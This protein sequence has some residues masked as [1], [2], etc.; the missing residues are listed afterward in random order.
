MRRLLAALFVTAAMLA[1][2]VLAVWLSIEPPRLDRARSLSPEI[3]DANGELLRA[4][5]TPASYWRLD[6]RVE[7]VSPLYLDM[8]IAYEDARFASHLGVD[9]LAL[10][11]AG[12]QWLRFGRAVSGASTLTMQT[13]RLLE[14]GNHGLGY[15]LWQLGK[16]LA[17]E[18][19]ESK[20]EILALYLKLAPFGGNL[21]GVRAASLAYFGKEPLRLSAAEA[22]LLVA[23]PQG[24][25][26][27]PDRFPEAARVARDRVLS[28]MTDRGVLSREAAAAAMRQPVPTTRRPMPSV[29]AHVAQRLLPEAFFGTAVRTIIDG[30][31]QR[32]LER[33]VAIERTR[34]DPAANLAVLVVRNGD[35][36][37]VAAVGSAGLFDLGRAGQ[38]DL[39]RVI[40]SPGSALKPFVYGLAFETLLVH[41][42][43]LILDAPVRYGSY[44]PTNFEGDY[45]GLITVR[46][47][48]LRSLNTTAVAL[49][50]ALGAP[51]FVARLRAVGVP[52]RLPQPDAEAG[53]VIAVGGCGISL[54][55]LVTLYA[56]LAN[57]GIVR[58]PRYRAAEPD[59]LLGRLLSR[60]AA[61]A[62]ADILADARRPGAPGVDQIGNRR[63]IAYKTG[64]SAAYRD[65]WSAG[66]DADYTVGVWVGRPDAAPMPGHFGRIT[67]APLLFRVFD[68]LP[69]ALGDPA[70]P[71]PVGTPLAPRG[72]LPA[73]LVRFEPRPNAT[74]LP[75]IDQPG[76]GAE[77]AAPAN[78]IALRGSG[79]R[80]P[81][82]WFVN[83]GPLG[84]PPA[85]VEAVWRPKGRGNAKLDLIDADGR[86][87]S[88][89]VWVESIAAQ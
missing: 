25:S 12:L 82:R 26:R 10:L 33:L 9:P 47:A 74:T 62:V 14:P 1:A 34:L 39:T 69:E 35:A 78:G 48:L 88:V 52:L 68:L 87:S 57:H 13:V 37:V 51:R 80:P 59:I 8:L 31:L 58:L 19:A 21:E 30:M 6:V 49:L 53:P 46:E 77:I 76:D 75:N 63:R 72:D 28:R 44:T 4:F 54:E 41:P 7:D 84:T 23:L 20:R 43:T 65:A 2:A 64:T 36:A 66:F 27:R 32:K 83:G 24:P 60:D 67:A 79:G 22:A 5:A 55:Q 71:A 61:W 85:T 17:L 38:V 86:S 73:R 29:A 18:R 42:D 11:R 50:D 81:Y 45:G 16:A 3:K 40:R 89:T 70:G 15:K 56:G